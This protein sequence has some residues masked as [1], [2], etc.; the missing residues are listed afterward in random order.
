[1]KPK[2]ET[3]CVLA[4]AGARVWPDGRISPCCLNS[5]P[6]RHAN[7]EEFYLYKDSMKA[8]FHSADFDSLRQNLAKGEQDP[9]CSICWDREAAGLESKRQQENA[10]HPDLIAQIERGE[11]FAQPEILDLN[12]G[13]TCNLKCRSCGAHSSSRWVQELVDIYRQDGLARHN[14]ELRQMSRPESRKRLSSW[15]EFTEEFWSTLKEWAP[16]IRVWYFAGGEP[17]LNKRHQEALSESVKSGHSKKQVLAYVTN[18][19]IRPGQDLR[20]LWQNFFGI[21]V[22]LSA[23]GLGAQF[24]YLRHGAKWNDFLDNL[25]VFRE[26][27]TTKSAM[28]V[29]FTCS[30]FNILSLPEFVEFFLKKEIVISLT[31]VNYPERFCIQSMPLALKEKVCEKLRADPRYQNPQIRP[32]IEQAIQFMQLAN[33]SKY[34]LDFLAN[35]PKHDQYREESFA[36]TFPEMSTLIDSLG[37]YGNKRSFFLPHPILKQMRKTKARLAA[38]FRSLRRSVD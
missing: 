15:Y 36:L 14:E 26:S 23:D 33:Q 16:K 30:I 13:T 28:V 24:E 3:I 34:W 11:S 9:R 25:S 38:S 6:G 22:A 35:V 17:L 1:M 7:G 37:L 10:K 2:S 20:A 32:F 19:T 21:N 31:F 12:I 29:N 18:G 8:A 27:C 5:I 4:C